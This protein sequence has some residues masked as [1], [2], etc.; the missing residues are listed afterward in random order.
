MENAVKTQE[1]L[2]EVMEQMQ[3]FSVSSAPSVA[4]QPKAEE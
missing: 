1:I 2:L 3:R 4:Q